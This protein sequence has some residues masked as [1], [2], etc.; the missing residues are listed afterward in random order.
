MVGKTVTIIFTALA[1]VAFGTSAY[2][3][4]NVVK[5]ESAKAAA[6]GADAA[7]KAA[8]AAAKDG[9]STCENAGWV[10]Y[11]LSE[12]AE[13]TI[14]FDIGPHGFAWEK[15]WKVAIPAGGYETNAIASK[16]VITNK[17]PGDITVNCQRQ[18]FDRHDWKID[19]GSGKTYQPN[20]QMDHVVPQ[21][22]IEPGFGQPE[23]TERDVGGVIGGQRGEAAR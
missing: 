20:Y 2:A 9:F 21:T 14:E 17:G 18:L 8:A 16:S 22:Y 1:F 11:N 13:T 15:V 12:T 3:N 10:V 7:A 23:G 6:A 5:P 4:V 19:A